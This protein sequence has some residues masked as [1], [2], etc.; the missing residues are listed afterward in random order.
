[1]TTQTTDI[2]QFT[3]YLDLVSTEVSSRMRPTDETGEFFEW[4]ISGNTITVTDGFSDFEDGQCDEL[5][6]IL[7]DVITVQVSGLDTYT[8]GSVDELIEWFEQCSWRV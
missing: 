5:V 1:M 2:Q 8:F 3:Q 6:V 4:E 7:D